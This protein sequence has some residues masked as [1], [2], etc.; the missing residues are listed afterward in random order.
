MLTKIRVGFWWLAGYGVSD[1][2]RNGELRFLRSYLRPG[3]K[4]VDVGANI[5][6]FSLAALSVNPDVSIVA[7]EPVPEAFRVLVE[8]FNGNDHVHCRRV[9]LG[10]APAMTTI[11]VPKSNDGRGSQRSSLHRRQSHGDDV[12][13]IRVQIDCLDKQFS[14]GIDFLKIDVE[15][16]ELAVL[17][18]AQQLLR[19]QKI[20]C[21]QFEYG[22]TFADAG[23]TLNEVVELL[24][25]HGYCV[26]RLTPF[27]QISW[28]R[29]QQDSY[30][31]S[32]WIARPVKP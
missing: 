26:A 13:S 4:L 29:G 11:H 16:H 3:M 6:E 7:F 1:P 22:G 20:S 27:G 9:A 5:G 32:N 24:Q 2:A 21:L 19:Q 10:A 12:E 25:G 28:R 30:R 17:Q 23:V 31:Y 8:R 15:G 14:E 18:G